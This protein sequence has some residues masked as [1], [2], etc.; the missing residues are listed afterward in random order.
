[1]KQIASLLLIA[2]LLQS[3]NK[4]ANHTPE[5]ENIKIT[6]LKKFVTDKIVRTDSSYVNFHEEDKPRSLHNKFIVLEVLYE[7]MLEEPIGFPETIIFIKN[8]GKKITGN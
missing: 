7:N 8:K 1:M 4:W 6:V 2:C 5:K 3:C